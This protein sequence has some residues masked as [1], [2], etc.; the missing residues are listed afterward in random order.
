MIVEDLH[1]EATDGVALRA[2]HFEPSGAARA[3]VVVAGGT[4]IPRRFYRPFA[5]F[6]AERGAAVLT[7]DYRA[8]GE[9][10]QDLRRSKARMRDWA[11]YDVPGAI[12][13]MR[14]RYS[15]LALQLVGH[16]YGGQALLLAPNNSEVARAVAVAAQAGYWRFMGGA[17]K[18]RIYALM[19]FAI[20]IVTRAFGY[21]PCS[22]LGF[23]EDLASG[24]ML[25]WRKWILMRSYFFSDPTLASLG[26]AQQFRGDLLMIGLSDDP[27]ATPRAIDVLANGF[28]AARVVRR[29]INPHDAGLE[30]IGHMGFFRSENGVALWPQI[31]AFLGLQQSNVEEFA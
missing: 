6:L 4:A 12:R 3:A 8:S 14:E 19:N 17:E 10:P 13:F 28:T 26:N 5:Q 30:H 15:H 22:R 18:Y 9:P 25:E 2:T 27:W 20:P 23:G 7:F 1:F 29:E 31:A 11:E 16:S 21:A 24:V